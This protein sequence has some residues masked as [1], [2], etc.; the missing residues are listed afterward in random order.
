MQRS[1][2]CSVNST[3]YFF[4]FTAEM[5]QRKEFQITSVFIPAV[6]SRSDVSKNHWEDLV[7]F[8]AEAS[9]GRAEVVWWVATKLINAASA[10]EE[11]LSTKREQLSP[12]VYAG[13]FW[14]ATTKLELH[15]TGGKWK[16]RGGE[17]KWCSSQTV[18]GVE[19]KLSGA[20]MSETLKSGSLL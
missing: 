13:G 12:Q 16:Q 9:L 3:S 8:R 19:M 2:K 15:E 17:P 18:M 6:R 20:G 1:W 14:P 7:K 5:F 4:F 10:W 11:R